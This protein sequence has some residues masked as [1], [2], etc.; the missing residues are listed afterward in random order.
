MS[1][2]GIKLVLIYILVLFQVYLNKE[3]YFIELHLLFLKIQLSLFV[4]IFPHI[5]FVIIT[6]LGKKVLI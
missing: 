6:F 3:L 4:Y 5:D 2:I 1:S